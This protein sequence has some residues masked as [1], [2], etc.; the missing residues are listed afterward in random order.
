MHRLQRDWLKRLGTAP[1][2]MEV[3]LAELSDFSQP[4]QKI[5]QLVSQ[6]VL[7]RLKRG[8]FCVSP[9]YSG[10]NVDVRKVANIL[11][12]PSYVSFETMLAGYGLIPERVVET[13]SAVTGRGKRF[14]TPVGRFIYR[15]VPASTFALGVR[16]VEG[17]MVASPEKALCD[18]LDSRS[19]LRISSPRSLRTYLEEDVRF[20]FDAFEDPDLRIF[21]AYAASGR[22]SNL[23]KALERMFS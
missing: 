20:D 17:A 21:S 22:K 11:Y 14:M 4:A 23:F 13:I 6:G 9:D 16:S 12:G 7:V 19:G 1:F 5:R 8:M 15:T 10:M 18:F 2:G 3:L